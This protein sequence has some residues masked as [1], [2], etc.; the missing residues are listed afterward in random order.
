[1]GSDFQQECSVGVQK[2]PDF[3][4]SQIPEFH[5]WDVLPI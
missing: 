3:G 1:M 2:A 5:I 4:T